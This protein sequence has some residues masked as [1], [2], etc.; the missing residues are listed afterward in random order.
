MVLLTR[1]P[2]KRA[3]NIRRR[4]LTARTRT[5]LYTVW[6]QPSVYS[7]TNCSCTLETA[8]EMN[9]EWVGEVWGGRGARWWGDGQP[10]EVVA[11]GLSAADRRP[12]RTCVAH[13]A[14]VRFHAP[15]MR[16]VFY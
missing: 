5:L 11:T 7:F 15:F 9:F 3:E 16:A 14:A 8:Q 4:E 12:A 6:H 1:P 10:G 2:A 13:A